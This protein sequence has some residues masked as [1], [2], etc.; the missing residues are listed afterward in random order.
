MSFNQELDA[1]LQKKQNENLY[2]VRRIAESAHSVE[3]RIDGQDLITFCSNN[4]LGLANHPL[5]KQAAIDGVN[6]WGVGGGSAHL[7]NGHSQAHHQLEEQLAEYAGYERALL[8]PSGYMANMGIAS[9]LLGRSDVV[10]ED[11]LNHASLIDAAKMSGAKL[12]RYQHVN[13]ESLEQQLQKHSEKERA[14]VMTDSVF[15]MD[16]NMAPLKAISQLCK[17]YDRPLMIDDAHGFGVLGE[18]GSGSLEACGLSSDDVPIMMATLGKA[19]GVS[20]AFVAGSNSLIETLIQQA[21]TYVYT[22]ACPPAMAAATSKAIE[23]IQEEAW[24][25]EKLRENIALLK[26]EAEQHG[27][28]LMLSNTAIQPINIGTADKALR[29]SQELLTQGFLVPAIR[30]PTVPK[31]TSRLR[32]TLSAEHSSEQIQQ[33]IRVLATLI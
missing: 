3:M 24:R 13:K 26:S 14:L 28:S 22:T 23:L 10:V 15:S 12:S 5:I 32:I 9:A 7:V 6:K 2:R 21:R 31:N 20:G 30:P 29:V 27:L 17:Q 4:Y 1:A 8:F 19:V 16:G 18:Q 33:L 25:R 11:K